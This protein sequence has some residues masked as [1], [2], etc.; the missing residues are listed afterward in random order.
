[1]KQLFYVVIGAII[2]RLLDYLVVIYAEQEPTRDCN[3]YFT[4]EFGGWYRY[5]QTEMKYPWN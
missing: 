2:L 3:D 1:M 5:I 4:T